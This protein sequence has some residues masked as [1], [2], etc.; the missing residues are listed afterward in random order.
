[1][2]T[3]AHEPADPAELSPGPRRVLPPCYLLPAAYGTTRAT[4]VDDYDHFDLESVWAGLEQ[5]AR[6]MRAV[7]RLVRAGRDP[8]PA[9]GGAAGPLMSPTQ[10]VWPALEPDPGAVRAAAALEPGDRDGYAALVAQYRQGAFAVAAHQLPAALQPA[11]E[12]ILTL[13]DSPTS[14]G[15]RDF[16][17]YCGSLLAALPPAVVGEALYLSLGALA[18]DPVVA[19]RLQVAKLLRAATLRAGHALDRH[20]LTGPAAAVLRADP[21][22]ATMHPDIRAQAPM[23]RQGPRALQLLAIPVLLR[24]GAAPAAAGTAAAAAAA[25]AEPPARAPGDGGADP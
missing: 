22:L 8:R 23:D 13:A 1:M 12:A 14:L 16:L 20:P 10:Q 19:V 11:F 24:R 2:V 17:V 3:L 4:H 15:R 9:A 6:F 25:A 7:D 21:G 18:L 5:T